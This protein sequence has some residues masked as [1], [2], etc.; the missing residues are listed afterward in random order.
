MTTDEIQPA[1]IRP[2]DKDWTWVLDRPCPECGFAAAEVTVD[3][4]ATVVRDNATTWEA[5]LTLE[6]AAARPT[7]S[8]WSP[9][10]YACHVRDVH[11]VF[12][13]RVGLMLEQ[14]EPTFANWDQDETA[15]AEQYAEQDPATVAA[16]LLDAAEGVAERYE[17]VPSGAWGRRGRR[18]N[19]SEFTIESL[20][21]YHLH[22]IVH[23]AWDVRTAV[24]RA[25]LASYDEAAAAYRDGA[26]PMPARVQADVDE[27]AARLGTGGRVLE[28]GSGPG[29]DAQALEEAGLSVR[30]TD[31]APAFVEQLRAAG[32]Q[33]DLLDPLHD[34]LDDP[35]RPGTAY[36]AVW[37][38]ASLLHVA[39]ADLPTVLRRLAGAVRADGALRFSVKEGD[40][41]RWSVHGDVPGRRHFVLWRADPLREVVESSGWADVRVTASVGE[42]TGQPWL[43]VWAFRRT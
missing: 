2:D 3:R 40:G 6:D 36:D 11:R 20:G 17:S 26:P 1:E 7:P 39:R 24:A 37:A 18:S 4:L 30:R 38:N 13:L 41:E 43:E 5:V 27:L 9:L 32:H 10:E 8:T 25:T 28:I 34:D 14:D 31:L 29:R 33:A 42:Q 16:E 19:G 12:D 21:Q 15:V 35:A 22:D 23:H